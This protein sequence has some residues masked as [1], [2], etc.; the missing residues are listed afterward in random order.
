MNKIYKVIWSKTKNCYVVVSEIAKRHTKSNATGRSAVRGLLTCTVLLS[1]TAGMCSP[2][3]AAATIDISSGNT[4]TIVDGQDVEARANG[5][6]IML[7]L[8][9]INI[10]NGNFTVAENGTVTAHG[11]TIIDANGKLLVN[12]LGVYNVLN[13]AYNNATI[14]AAGSNTATG[15]YAKSIGSGTTAIGDFSTA[16]GK[17]LLQRG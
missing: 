11:N 15:Q 5:N 3:W 6:N 9:K 17:A 8:K 16:W 13:D 12:S 14:I 2:V 1:L 4:Y 10:G 7:N